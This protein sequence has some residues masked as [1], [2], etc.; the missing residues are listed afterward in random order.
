[1]RFSIK[2]ELFFL[3]KPKQ[4]ENNAPLRSGA[5]RGHRPTSSMTM[6]CCLR[7]SGAGHGMPAAWMR[8]RLRYSFSA[9]VAT[10]LRGF[11]LA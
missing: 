10:I 9:H 11:D 6:T 5:N 8:A 2:K 3:K 7:M 4:R 1:M